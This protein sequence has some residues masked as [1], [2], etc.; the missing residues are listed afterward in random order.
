MDNLVDRVY[1]LRFIYKYIAIIAFLV[2]CRVIGENTYL[3]SIDMY[4]RVLLKLEKMVV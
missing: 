3:M 2:N 1:H 4:V